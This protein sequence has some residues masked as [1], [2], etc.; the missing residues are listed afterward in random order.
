M[1][2]PS[3]ETGSKATQLNLFSPECCCVPDFF[4]PFEF[5]VHL[6]KYPLALKPLIVSLKT[7]AAVLDSPDLSRSLKLP[8][9]SLFFLIQNHLKA[10]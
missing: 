10:W 9:K 6:R 1:S 7:N 8:K 4:F 2:R 3:R 5:S